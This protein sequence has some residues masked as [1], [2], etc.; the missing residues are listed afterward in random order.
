MRS[1]SVTSAR[2]HAGT[3]TRWKNFS[4]LGPMA[5]SKHNLLSGDA[6]FFQTSCPVMRVSS[7]PF[8]TPTLSRAPWEN[9]VYCITVYQFSSK[10]VF[11]WIHLHVHHRARWI[12]NNRGS[13]EKCRGGLKEVRTGGKASPRL[14]Q[15]GAKPTD[16][17]NINL[18]WSG[19]LYF[20][21]RTGYRK[22]K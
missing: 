1:A 13:K 7:K 18:Y 6:C 8:Q 19:T 9:K 3:S 12:K 4:L 11:Y 15:P 16:E 10:I 20:L 5:R 2:S 22:E 21:R 17:K 14:V